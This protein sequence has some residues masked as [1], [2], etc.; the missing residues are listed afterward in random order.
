MTEDLLILERLVDKWKPILYIAVALLG[1]FLGLLVYTFVIP[2]TILEY[3]SYVGISIATG[4]IILASYK[5]DY[6]G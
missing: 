2:N 5:L 3:I 4:L 1:A 6:F